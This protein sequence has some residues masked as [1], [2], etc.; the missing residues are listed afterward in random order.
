MSKGY[1]L[2]EKELRDIAA[3]C[4]REQGRTKAGIQACA[5][6]MCNYHEHYWANKYDSPYQTVIESGWYGRNVQNAF[7]VYK[8]YVTDEMVE[9]V[10]E[11]MSG[12][13]TL[14]EYVVEYDML[15]DIKR[16]TNHGVSIDKDDR[17][18]YVKDVTKIHNIYGNAGDCYTFYCFPDGVEGHCDAFGYITKPK[19][20]EVENVGVT[21]EQILDIFRGWIGRKEANGTH[22]AIIDLYNSYR[23][24]ARGYA[25]KYTDQWCDTCL[26]AGFI[27]AGAVDLIGGT[28]CGVEEHVKIFQR[29]GIWIEDGTITPQPGDIIVYNW[30]KATQPNDGWSDHIGIV[31]KVGTRN[32]TTI[33]GNYKDSVARRVIAIG[34]GN[35]RGFARPVYAVNTTE[36]IIHDSTYTDAPETPKNTQNEVKTGAPSKTVKR[37]G[38]VT[39]SALNV[40]TWAGTEYPRLKSYPQLP[41]GTKV[42]V[43]DEVKAKDGATWLYINYAGIYGFVS[44]QYIS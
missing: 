39:A 8:S 1:N 33:E 35:I 15:G 30:G 18:Q 2:S 42:G 29:K 4:F 14:P 12:N 32:I 44:A 5:S 19:E 3:V 21:A 40:R 20:K 36:D 13:R 27:K 6:Q 17:S 41:R 22:R 38:T 11:V 25:V 34:H 28:E 31:E 26:S 10:R 37:T 9:W 43:C 16:A 23:P 7:V 24:L